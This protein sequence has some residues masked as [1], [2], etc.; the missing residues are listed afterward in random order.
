MLAVT[1]TVN[2][3]F[4]QVGNSIS[5]LNALVQGT[6]RGL[7]QLSEHV[8]RMAR[9]MS[10]HWVRSYY[11]RLMQIWIKPYLNH[12]IATKRMILRQ[13]QTL[14]RAAER[15]HGH[16]LPPDVLPPTNLQDA[17][18]KL[19]MEVKQS[20]PDYELVL[21]D[22]RDYYG[23]TGIE[24]YLQDS[25]TLFLSI[26]VYLKPVTEPVSDLWRLEQTWV[27]VQ[28]ADNLYTEV[29]DPPDMLAISER[30]HT[31]LRMHDLRRCLSIQDVRLCPQMQLSFSG[32]HASCASSIWRNEPRKHVYKNCNFTVKRRSIHASEQVRTVWMHAANRRRPL[33]K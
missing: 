2:K 9:Q 12:Q 24:G 26:P 13:M 7:Q 32:Q 19:S 15:L 28:D 31:D 4:R 23:L 3:G 17:L 6:A 16:Q 25:D 30:K 18:N 22:A 29:R 27:P 10:R 21:T 1:K 14:R 33:E 20:L 8:Q 5:K 11:E